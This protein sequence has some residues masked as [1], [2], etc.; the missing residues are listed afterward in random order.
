MLAQSAPIAALRDVEHFRKTIETVKKGRQY[1]RD[2]L[3]VMG[4]GVVTEPQGNFLMVK[5]SPNGF[6]SE[7]FSKELA[8]R[9]F[10]IRGGT[11]DV[12]TDYVR[13]SVGTDTQNQH[14]VTTIGEIVE[15]QSKRV[16]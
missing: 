7:Q 11:E 6:T 15:Q 13:I 5:V 16:G 8:Q 12:G 2:Q 1:L 14:L 10:S 4:F 9:G 3:L